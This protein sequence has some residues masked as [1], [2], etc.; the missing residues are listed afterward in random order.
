[1]SAY[2]GKKVNIAIVHHNSRDE[3]MVVMDC[4]YMWSKD[5]HMHCVC[6]GNTDFNGHDTHTDVEWSEWN[7]TDSLPTASGNY[8]LANNINLAKEQT[9]KNDINICLNGKTIKSNTSD[10]TISVNSNASLTITD[11]IVGGKLE[12]SIDNYGSFNMYAG[13]LQSGYTLCTE[14]DS[15][16][17]LNGNSKF[18]G[19]VISTGNAETK[20]DG[21]SEFQGTLLIKELTSDSRAYIGG[22]AKITGKIQILLSQENAKIEIKDNM[23]IDGDIE[24]DYFTL[25]SNIVC[26]GNIISGI[27]K[28]DVENNGTITGGTFLGKV[29]GNGTIADSATV[30][31]NFNLDGGTGTT[32]QKVLRGQKLAEPTK[33]YKSAYTFDGWYNG[34]QKYDFDA[35]VFDE[36]TLTAKWTYAGGSSWNTTEPTTE[37]PTEPTTKPNKQNKSK[38]TKDKTDKTD[39]NSLSA[40]AKKADAN[41][42]N[43][44]KSPLTGNASI[45]ASIISTGAGLIILAATKKRKDR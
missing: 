5:K 38:N 31:V 41:S 12:C 4:M 39:K 17:T 29:T 23:I 18:I 34:K 32:L 21:N 25:N 7:S 22:D 28:G 40:G 42:N 16:M 37:K 2:S 8:Y 13:T 44:E 36:I 26:N 14:P 33:P 10:Y 43:Y 30:N 20:I 11:C 24:F 6:G 15:K 45:F 27:F 35:P 19:N 1:M 9:V 3:Y